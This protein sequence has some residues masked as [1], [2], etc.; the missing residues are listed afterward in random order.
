MLGN[1]R[2]DHNHPMGQNNLGLSL[3]TRNWI[4]AIVRGKVDSG[5]IVRISFFQV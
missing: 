2:A 3:K 5:H 4:A 1:Y